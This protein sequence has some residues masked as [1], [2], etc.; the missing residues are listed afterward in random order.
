[1]EPPTGIVTG[2]CGAASIVAGA[3]SPVSARTANAAVVL[4]RD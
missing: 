2:D 1:M 3:S 4:F